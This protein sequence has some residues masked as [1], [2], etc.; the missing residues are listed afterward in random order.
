MDTVV[1]TGASRGI[2]GAIAKYTSSLGYHVVATSRRIEDASEVVKDIHDGGGAASAM[3]LDVRDIA[4]LERCASE[5]YELNGNL[6]GWI[7]NA[8]TSMMTPFLDVT[9]DQFDGTMDVNLKGV[10][11]GI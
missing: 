10:Y 9:E 7:N 3:Q 2:G 1:I 11:F 4:D 5:S 8:G 6:Y